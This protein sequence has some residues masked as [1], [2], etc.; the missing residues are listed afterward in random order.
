[1]NPQLKKPTDNN[2][3]LAGGT[4]AYSREVNGDI[5]LPDADV[6]GLEP[7]RALIYSTPSLGQYGS[8][9]KQ[10]SSAAKLWPKAA[11]E[12]CPVPFH[13]LMKFES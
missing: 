1:M 11:L 2:E 6:S 12:V 3:S 5:Q 13:L 10:A 9:R 8:I 7:L 4:L